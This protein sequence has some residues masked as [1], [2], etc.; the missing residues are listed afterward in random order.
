MLG[1]SAR[2]FLGLGCLRLR[3][4]RS[5]GNRLSRL[6]L[7]WLGL[8]RFLVNVPQID[9]RIELVS[10]RLWLARLGLCTLWLCRLLTRR[11]LPAAA[12]PLWGLSLLAGGLRILG[13]T[14]G[15]RPAGDFDLV[16]HVFWLILLI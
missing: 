10:A 5:L 15:L 3:G 14:L 4:C 8:S 6:S 7:G 13:S 1:N 16:S 11:C 12:L 9:D 2:G